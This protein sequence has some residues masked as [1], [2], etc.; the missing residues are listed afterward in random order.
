MNEYANAML[1]TKLLQYWRYFLL[2]FEAD[3]NV[4][5]NSL[6]LILQAVPFWRWASFLGMVVRQRSFFPR[7]GDG[8]KEG[9]R[10]TSCR[11]T[12]P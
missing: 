10:R 12:R 11:N 3:K 6:Y 1:P 5:V 2:V 9:L 7:N 4:R 8:V